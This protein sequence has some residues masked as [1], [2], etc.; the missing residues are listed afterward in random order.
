ML[1]LSIRGH[2]PPPN[3]DATEET[4]N[5]L[6]EPGETVEN[7]SV[8][9]EYGHNQYSSKVF[10]V[11]KGG[12]KEPTKVIKVTYCDKH[13]CKKTLR[14]GLIYG[15]ISKRAGW[16]N[17]LLP[18][19][20]HGQKGSTFT[21][22]IFDYVPGKD[23]IDRLRSATEPVRR[24]ILIGG[25][26][27]LKFLATTGYLHGDVKPDNLWVTPEDDV[28][29]FDLADAIRD[30]SSVD[31]RR[32]MASVDALIGAVL[33]RNSARGRS[34]SKNVTR[35]RNRSRS[36]SPRREEVHTLE[37]LVEHYGRLIRQYESV[38]G[39]GKTRRSK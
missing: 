10:Y 11:K 21:Y 38:R 34:R 17:Y 1:G 29:L 2:R 15:E 19:R 28:R 8:Q 7:V 31:I 24:G 30:P 4:V 9:N 14:E 33:G 20:E 23:M 3:N 13:P 18:Y 32:E 37:D 5:S 35:N 27:A 26:R 39:G 6:V 25:L 22:I 16:K 12:E 36:R